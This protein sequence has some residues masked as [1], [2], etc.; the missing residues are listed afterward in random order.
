MKSTVTFMYNKNP[1]M[2]LQYLSRNIY[3]DNTVTNV[4]KKTELSI[5][6]VHQILKKFEALGIAVGHQIGKSIVYEINKQHP[7][8]KPFKVFSNIVE[9]TVLIEQ[10]KN[11]SYKVILFGSC[12]SGEDDNNSDID[13]CIVAEDENKS[14]INMILEEYSIERTI[15]PIIINTFELMNMEKEDNV[16]YNQIMKGNILWEG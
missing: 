10:I 15:N 11:V 5:G 13:L 6:S 14:E 4:A 12:A 9:L 2:V 16:F 3:S 8:V 7:L 1:L